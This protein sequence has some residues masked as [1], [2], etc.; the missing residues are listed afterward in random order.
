MKME[1][2]VKATQDGKVGEILVKEGDAVEL[3]QK[4]VNMAA[5]T[6]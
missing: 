3:K 6:E 5:K 1:Y 2:F 4:L